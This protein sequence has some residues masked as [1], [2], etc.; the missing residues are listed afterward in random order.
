MHL[1]NFLLQ[2]ALGSASGGIITI[3]FSI[4]VV[5]ILFI[6]FRN[7]ILWYY[8]LDVIAKSQMAKP[9]Y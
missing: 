7:I 4:A 9:S 5:V 2:V 6:V 8:K 3:L 1:S